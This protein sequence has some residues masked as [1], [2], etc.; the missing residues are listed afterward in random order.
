[1]KTMNNITILWQSR[2]KIIYPSL[3]FYILYFIFGIF[4]CWFCWFVLIKESLW[5]VLLAMLLTIFFI[6]EAYEALNLESITLT[7]K[8]LILKM[9]FDKDIFYP[10]GQF[11]IQSVIRGVIRFE[12]D[13]SFISNQNCKTFKMPNGYDTFGNFY[14]NQTFK[15]LCTKY[16]QQALESLNLQER[17]NLY[18]LYQSNVEHVFNEIRNHNVFTIDFSLYKAEIESYLKDKNE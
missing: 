15:D 10:Y 14:N 8:G 4:M 6:S 1:M 2:R 12:E 11:T 7:D 5:Y 9:K 18:K 3:F 13:L 17:A 16:T